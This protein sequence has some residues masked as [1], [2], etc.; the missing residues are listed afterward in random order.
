ML[1]RYCKNLFS[2]DTKVVAL[3]ALL[4]GLVLLT[5]AFLFF[6]TAYATRGQI[7]GNNGTIKIDG[8]VFDSHPNNE[9]HPGCTFQVDF[10]NYDQGEL[11]ASALFEAIPPTAGGTILQENNIFIGEDPAGGGTDLDAS[12]TYNLSSALAGILPHPIQG[13]HIKLTV[14]ADGSQGD[15]TKHKVFWVTCPQ[16]S[17][18]PRPL[19]SPSPEVSPSPSPQAS[20]SP[21]PSSGGFGGVSDGQGEVL[22]ETV[23]SEAQKQGQIL[24]AQSFAQTGVFAE[25]LA[26]VVQVLGIMIASIG[27]ARYAKKQV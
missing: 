2:S 11:F 20:P 23:T 21:S 3:G 9:P 6:R 8:V 16:V 10:Y 24:G 19:P 18:S 1:S 5:Q 22:G 27:A 14:H 12:K 13:Y 7:P 26:K 4:C 25:E 15:D 17:P